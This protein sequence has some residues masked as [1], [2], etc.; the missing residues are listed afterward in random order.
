MANLT[1]QHCC[2]AFVDHLRQI[3]RSSP[4]TIEAYRRDLA[5]FVDHLA[6]PHTSPQSS[7]RP[8]GDSINMQALSA[9]DVRSYVNQ[10]RVRGLA[11]RSVHRKL[12]SLR[13]LFRYYNEFHREGLA[14]V[15]PC[16][17]VSAPRM[18]RKLPVVLDVDEL[19]ALFETQAGESE[20][21]FLVVRDLAMLELFYGAGLRLAEL[22]ALNI[23]SIDRQRNELVVTGKGNKQ[24]VLPLGSGARRALDRWLPLRKAFANEEENALFL[25]AGGKRLG[26]RGIQLRVARAAHT[27][28]HAQKLHPHLL[29]HCFASHLLES[30]GD[31][32]AVQELLGHA[33]LSTTQIYTHLDFQ[34]LASVYDAHHP[35]AQGIDS[36]PGR[37]KKSGVKPV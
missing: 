31:L 30:S 22:A 13:A 20:E 7:V 24:R 25:G 26:H 19:S 6:R 18:P 21:H 11:T 9:Q 23:T 34:Q 27:L 28:E 35:R 4:H 3:R 1:V 37:G 17:A 5:Q 32:R 29:R 10:L 15:D 12:S 36:K 2:A 8:E 14:P 16:Q 33:N